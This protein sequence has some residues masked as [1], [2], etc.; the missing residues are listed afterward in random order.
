M[1][2]DPQAQANRM[3]RMVTDEGGTQPIVMPPVMFDEDAGPGNPAPNFGQHTNEVLAEIGGFT[4]ERI[5]ELRNSG[6]IA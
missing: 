3:I 4:Q 2:N 6:A 1:V 5:A